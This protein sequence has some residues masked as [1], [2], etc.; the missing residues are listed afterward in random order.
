MLTR[1]SF[2]CFDFFLLEGSCISDKRSFLIAMKFQA[3]SQIRIEKH[4]ID[5][6]E[7]EHLERSIDIFC[8]NF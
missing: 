8:A 6:I 1:S 2:F 7:H 3:I 4:F 5:S